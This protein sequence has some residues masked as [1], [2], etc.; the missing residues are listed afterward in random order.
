MS[1]DGISSVIWVAALPVAELRVSLPLA[2]FYYHL[3]VWQAVL[4]S[5]IGNAIPVAI[6]F[7]FFPPLFRFAETHIPWL[8]RLLNNHIR[9]LE[10]KYAER[11]QRYGAFFLFLFVAA[12]IPGS[13][14]WTGSL[15]AII[16][17]M[18]PRYSV[19]AI[20]FGMMAAALIV[21]LISLYAR[22]I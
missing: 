15:L 21:L 7:L 14:V 1:M 9:K 2:L 12:P 3:P 8:H 10:Q 13:G 22:A 5:V 19:P 17:G 18:R 6:M 11:Y 16:F 20:L 4:F